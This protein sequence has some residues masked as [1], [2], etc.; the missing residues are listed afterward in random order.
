MSDAAFD[1]LLEFVEDEL[2]FAT[3]HYNDSY[4]DRRVSSRMRRT[5]SET[6]ATYLET[7]RNDPEEQTALLEAMSINVTGFF[8]NPDVWDGIREVL[9]RLTATNETVR[10]WSAACADGREPYSVSMLAH[11]DPEIDESSVSILGTDISEPALETARS[12]VY[13][14]SRTVDFADQLGYLDDY[15][16]Y[17]E[18]DD[19][20]F[21]I[22][23]AVKRNVTFERHDLINDSP[24]TGFDLVI[25]R[26][27]FIY[28]DN[29]Y[30]Q[31]MLATIAQ[32]LR[33]Q[34]YL[35]IGKAETIP[36]NLKSAFTVRDAR[37][38]IYHRDTLE[39]TSLTGE[40]PTSK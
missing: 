26:N 16:A 2:A 13:E 8:R 4:L 3:S 33:Q 35:V 22:A 12:G 5:Q 39:T 21:R 10:V 11:D 15:D 36:P 23:P 30:K 19:R 28:I 24:K 9:Q 18:R 34:G 20:I 32:S 1:E 38:R 14:E 17:V 6:Y 40:K 37:L 25:C 27:L 31:S 29:E 7:L